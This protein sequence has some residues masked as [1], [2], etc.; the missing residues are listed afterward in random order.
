MCIWLVLLRA[1]GWYFYMRMVGTFSYLTLQY[2]D[3]SNIKTVYNLAV[4]LLLINTHLLN[5]GTMT[6]VE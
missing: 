2:G 1:Y 3:K 5:D 4:S 6:L